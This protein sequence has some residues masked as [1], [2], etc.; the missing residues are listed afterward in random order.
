[1]WGD[2]NG[3]LEKTPRLVAAAWLILAPNAL[4]QVHVLPQNPTPVDET[5][6]KED[7]EAAQTVDLYRSDFVGKG[8]GVTGM[9]WDRS[10]YNE[11]EIVFHV[12]ALT[13]EI[14]ARIPSTLNGI[15]T[16]IW[17]NGMGRFD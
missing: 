11:P 7:K 12:K 2:S 9:T 5:R 15:P 3:T 6:A 1:M 8:P 4:A 17:P 14:K 10:E 16:F 13:P